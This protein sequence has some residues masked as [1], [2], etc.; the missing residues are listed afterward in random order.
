MIRRATIVLASLAAGLF[1]VAPAFAVGPGVIT[2]TVSPASVAP[3]VEVCVVEVQPSELCTAPEPSGKYRLTGVPVGPQRVEFVPSYR[4][5]Y[6]KQYFDHKSRLEEATFLQVS[7]PAGSEIKGIDAE[8]ELGSIIGGTVRAASGGAPLADVEVCVQGAG[9]GIPFG[10][11]TTDIAGMY[12][13]AGLPK[14]TYKVGFWGHGSSAKYAPES[15]LVEVPAASSVTG[16]DAE[17]AVGARIEGT[18]TAASTGAALSG[19]PVCLFAV[20]AAVPTRCAFTESAG[21][22]S[23]LGIAAGDYQIGFSLGAAELGGDSAFGESAGYLPQFYEDAAARSGSRSLSLVLGQIETGVDA[24]LLSV[25]QVAPPALP[26]GLASSP[27]SAAQVLGEPARPRA[28]KKKCRRGRGAKA[29]K[30]RST[31]GKKPHRK[32]RK[33][34]RDAQIYTTGYP[35]ID[36]RP[37]NP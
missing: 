19:I 1:A 34:A 2:G 18:V 10:C 29:S 24:A 11:S 5:G 20:G 15:T 13:L 6:L 16:I 4:S 17:L 23:L 31:C 21:T 33:R 12:A 28:R 8:L 14:G 30:A 25:P 9:T 37:V 27:T 7:P 22:Y 35:K 26:V 36:I 32:K 3:E